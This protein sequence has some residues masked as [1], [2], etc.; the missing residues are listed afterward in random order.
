MAPPGAESEAST[1]MSLLAKTWVCSHRAARPAGR[2]PFVRN[3]CFSTS[4]THGA[5]RRVRA[6][7]VGGATSD[8]PL[9]SPLADKLREMN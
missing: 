4:S 8:P 6:A 5:R 7:A 1:I 2:Y 3:S 9:P